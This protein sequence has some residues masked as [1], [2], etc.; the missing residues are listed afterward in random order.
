MDLRPDCRAIQAPVLAIQGHD[1][2]YGTL[3]QI[4]EIHPSGP[5]ERVALP[6]CGHSPHR[7]Q[8]QVTLDLMTRFLQALM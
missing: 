2:A 3:A 1:D 6:G 7:D 5:I 4:E 8:P